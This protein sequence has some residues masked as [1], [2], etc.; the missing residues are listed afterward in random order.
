EFNLSWSEIKQ[1]SRNSIS[2]SF[3]EEP[4]KGQLMRLF[5]ERMRKFEAQI[6]GGNNVKFVLGDSATKR[7]FIC[8]N[9][10]ICSD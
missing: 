7:G 9:Y 3:L 8:R 2:Y 1:L 4:E 6:Q 5:E 10:H